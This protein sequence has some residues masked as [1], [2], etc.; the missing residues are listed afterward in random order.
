LLDQTSLVDQ[1]MLV[2]GTWEAT[3]IE[4]MGR[5]YRWVNTQ[6]NPIFLDVGSYWGLYSML[7]VRSHVEHIHAFEADPKNYSQ[8]RSQLFLN[9]FVHKINV[10]HVAVSDQTG[11][12]T[13]RPSE[14]IQDGN[15]GSTGV[16][17][18][19]TT[20]AITLNCVSLDDIFDLRGATIIGKLD[21]EGH[22]PAVL[23]G[24]ARLVLQNRVFLQVEEFPEHHVATSTAA[25]S[26]GLR[27]VH[28]ITVDRYYTNIPDAELEWLT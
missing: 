14:K 17:A 26:V 2:N 12:L 20:D 5:A 7:A 15:R 24:M 10:H 18:P 23:R 11:T 1:A 13:F 19:E 21:V 3:Q 9:D 27:C 28:A 6:E 22:E 8:L 25:E 4:L 16:V